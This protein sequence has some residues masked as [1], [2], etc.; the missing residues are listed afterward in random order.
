MNTLAFPFATLAAPAGTTQNYAQV[1][2]YRTIGLLHQAR[3]LIT[4]LKQVEAEGITGI[5][6]HSAAGTAVTVPM[7]VE[8]EFQ[9]NLMTD[10]FEDAYQQ[11]GTLEDD[12]AKWCHEVALLREHEVE[13]RALGD[14][15]RELRRE[16]RAAVPEPAPAAPAP[17]LPFVP[18]QRPAA[19][20]RRP[21][22][23]AAT[24]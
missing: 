13:D 2:L 19:G 11:L 24:A 23:E 9:G 7:P 6:L 1:E 5:T 18:R 21:R 10:V 20:S 4:T 12:E 17:Q 15:A 8:F 14:A 3:A 22:T 16:M